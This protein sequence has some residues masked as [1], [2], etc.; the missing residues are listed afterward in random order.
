MNTMVSVLRMLTVTASDAAANSPD[1]AL[2]TSSQTTMFAIDNTRPTIDG[3]TVNYPHANARANDALSTI[4]EMAF[5]VDDQ[6]WQLGTTGDGLFD[7]Q[8]EDLR[9]DLPAGLTRGT[10]TLA[11][12]VADAAGNVGSTSVTFVVK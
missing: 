8:T 1:R 12:R 10:H 4:S 11:L 3:L 9:V 7:D 2:T 6:P 5:S